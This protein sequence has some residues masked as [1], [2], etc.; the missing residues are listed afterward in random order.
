MHPKDLHMCI[1]CSLGRRVAAMVF[2]VGERE[3]K[4]EN[5]KRVVVG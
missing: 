4:R 5:V 1:P 3:R 2:T